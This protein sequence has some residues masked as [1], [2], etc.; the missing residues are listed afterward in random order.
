ME[1]AVRRVETQIHGAE[2]P[3]LHFAPQRA[4][5][6][7][8]YRHLRHAIAQR[9]LGFATRGAPAAQADLPS[10]QVIGQRTEKF[11]RHEGIVHQTQ[12][13]PGGLRQ[14]LRKRLESLRLTQQQMRLAKQLLALGS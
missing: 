13:L 6:S 5:V 4:V 7:L 14:R 9:L 1:Q 12:R 8:T 10:G 3:P 11:T 2:R